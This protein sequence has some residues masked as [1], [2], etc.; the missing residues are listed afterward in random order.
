MIN[1]KHTHE[2]EKTHLIGEGWQVIGE[3]KHKRSGLPIALLYKEDN[4]H[5]RFYGLHTSPKKHIGYWMNWRD[6]GACFSARRIAE[7]NS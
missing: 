2:W 3:I 4:Y 1:W 6:L 7:D 5:P